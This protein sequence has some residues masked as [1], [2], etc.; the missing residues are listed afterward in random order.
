MYAIF[1]NGGHQHKAV[2]GDVL[3]LQKLDAEVG[4]E[5]TFAEVLI[6]NNDSETRVGNPYLPDAQITGTVVQQGR[7]KKLRIFKFKAKKNYKRQYGHRQSFTAVRID[8]IKA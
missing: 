7:G 3:V 2:P 6:V 4:E 1:Q 8:E 5:V